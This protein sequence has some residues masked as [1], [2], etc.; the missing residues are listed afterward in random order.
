MNGRLENLGNGLYAYHHMNGEIF[1]IQKLDI[2]VGEKVVYGHLM[3][4][5]KMY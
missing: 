5:I 1:A 4:R 2:D 3:T